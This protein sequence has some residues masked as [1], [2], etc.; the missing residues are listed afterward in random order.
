MNAY[1]QCAHSHFCSVHVFNLYPEATVSAMC[2]A[3]VLFSDLGSGPNIVDGNSVTDL[4]SSASPD[5]D[6]TSHNGPFTNIHP[7]PQIQMGLL[8]DGAFHKD[9]FTHLKP[10]PISDGADNDLCDLTCEAGSK[11]LAKQ[12]MK[13]KKEHIKL[14]QKHQEVLEAAEVWRQKSTVLLQAAQM[15][16]DRCC[17]EKKISEV[18]AGKVVRLLKHSGCNGQTC[19]TDSKEVA[20]QLIKVVAHQVYMNEKPAH[21]LKVVRQG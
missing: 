15:W 21:I 7:H 12:V 8:S 20:K 4:G 2:S 5:S 9:L 14:K 19:E 18:L 17:Q 3:G 6:G 1:M 13:V 10:S 11:E 16:K